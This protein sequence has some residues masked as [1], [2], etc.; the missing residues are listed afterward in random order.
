M[1]A[2]S[3]SEDQFI[4]IR[5]QA[6]TLWLKIEQYK[7]AYVDI[8]T[9]SQKIANIMGVLTI[10]LGAVTGLSG[11]AEVFGGYSKYVTLL[12]GFS[13][14][15]V[16]GVNQHFNWGERASASSRYLRDLDMIQF[17]V[18]THIGDI[19]RSGGQT[20]DP[21]FL[22]RLNE[23]MNACFNVQIAD[24]MRFE[25]E[26]REALLAH[27][28]HEAQFSTD[29][30]PASADMDIAGDLPVLETADDSMQPMRRG[31]HS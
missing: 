24:Y 19:S 20:Y 31:A 23:Q 27:W 7:R 25:N 21:T 3:C 10:V 8:A 6:C 30:E 5:S 18:E 12:L 15:V 29:I 16:A 13:T 11:F 2:E 9:H 4:N 1:P 26:A 14:A 17:E 22:I 28:I